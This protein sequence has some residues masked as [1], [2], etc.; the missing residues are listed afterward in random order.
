MPKSQMSRLNQNQPTIMENLN[1][2]KSKI[3]GL[4]IAAVGII[5][6][7]L[8]WWHVSFGG[9]YGIGG[10]Y[11]INGLHRLGI[12]TFI[13]FIGAGIVPVLLGDKTKPFEGQA[14]MITAALFGGAAFF[15]LLTLVFNLH[16]LS[17]GIFLA[18]AVGV[19][20]AL[21]VWGMVK[22]PENKPPTTPTPPQS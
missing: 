22:M 15:A 14:K 8:P 12:V 10:G 2:H 16:F 4:I 5:S 1:L 7:L 18:I 13:A 11:S 6:C 9:L 3:I 19:I 17:F 20:G 21:F